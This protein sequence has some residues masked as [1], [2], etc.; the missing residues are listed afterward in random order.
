VVESVDDEHDIGRF[1]GT[2]FTLCTREPC[3]LFR[4]T[5]LSSGA[6]STV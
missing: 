6:M 5:R 3:A 2:G 4:G 1:G